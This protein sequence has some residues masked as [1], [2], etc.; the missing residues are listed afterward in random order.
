MLVQ[1]FFS[2]ITAEATVAGLTEA[3]FGSS[4]A[5][6][7]AAVQAEESGASGRIFAAAKGHPDQE[8]QDQRIYP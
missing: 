2:K 7:G 5:A 8:R 3:F 4:V 1:V 6:L